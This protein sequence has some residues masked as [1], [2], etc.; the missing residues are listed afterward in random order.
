MITVSTYMDC[1]NNEAYMKGDI[2]VTQSGGMLLPANWD[3]IKGV[4]MKNRGDVYFQFDCHMKAQYG[5]D[6]I[7]Y[8]QNESIEFVDRK[9]GIMFRVSRFELTFFLNS[10]YNPELNKE[11]E[12]PTICISTGNGYVQWF[13]KPIEAIVNEWIEKNIIKN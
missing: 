12:S 8:P 6:K 3:E 9:E 1:T 2:L 4:V 11:H 13:R 10:L 7:D 5:L